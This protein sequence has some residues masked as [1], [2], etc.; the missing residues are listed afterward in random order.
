MVAVVGGGLW[1]VGGGWWVVVG[2]GVRV[3]FRIRLLATCCRVD[4]RC[5]IDPPTPTPTPNPN[6]N[7]HPTHLVLCDRVVPLVDVD[8]DPPAVAQD[9]VQ[10]LQ[11][12]L[13]CVRVIS[14]V[15]VYVRVICVYRPA[16]R[17]V[18]SCAALAARAHLP[19]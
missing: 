14:T 8:I 9:L 4:G 18:G 15:R 10:L 12:E 17:G 6:P 5:D 19:G 16:R 3:M 11:R 13:T 7:P 2:G 1:V